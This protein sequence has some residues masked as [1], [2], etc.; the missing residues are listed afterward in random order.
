M[1]DGSSGA[2]LIAQRKWILFGLALLCHIYFLQVYPN[3]LP[4]NEL[5]RLLLVSAIVD[6]H[7]FQI[8]QA[9]RRYS[10]SEDKARFEG[11]F[12]SDK[13]IGVSLVALPAFILM[14]LIEFATGTH[15]PTGFAICFL[16]VFTITV[17]ALLFL[18]LIARFWQ[19]LR[20][21]AEL[22]PEFLF[23]L[24]FG[25]IAF[26]YSMQLISHYLLG[27]LLF[28]SLCSLWS[29][30]QEGG[31]G[32][33]LFWAGTAAGLALTME[34]PAV[35]PV[36]LV[37]IYALYAIRK[38]KG[39]VIF[40]L[41]VLAFLL[42][43]LA[44]NNSIFGSPFDVTYR[45]MTDRHTAQHVQGV[46]GVALPSGEALYGLLLS[47]HHGL[48]FTSPFLLFAV[49][50]LVCLIR[51]KKWRIEGWIF[52]GIISC[53]VFVYSGFSYWIGG[54]AFGPRYFGPTI[55]FLTTAAYFFFTEKRARENRLLSVVGIASGAISIVLITAGSIT[56]PYPPDP[57][58]D[59]SFFVSFPL[60]V[61]G[62]YGWN[63]GSWIGLSNLG[64]ALLFYTLLFVTY[65]VAIVRSGTQEI[66]GHSS[67]KR[68][69]ICAT[70]VIVLLIAGFW[71]S[72][73]GD[74]REYYA[75]GLIYTFLAKYEPAAIDMREALQKKSDPQMRGRIERAL[76]QLENVLNNHVPREPQP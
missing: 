74:A 20:P 45:H 23:L 53:F 65:L 5:S 27:I 12:Y 24:T 3:F 19:K 46:V 4:P 25:T 58:R 63:V 72:P 14:R 11:H 1:I 26:T 17:P 66:P 8:D 70:I 32:K 33:R 55:P 52:S 56:F 40:A 54:W 38:I 69:L 59:P 30:K 49:P 21:E 44:Y 67:V 48:F 68:W 42:L 43:M 6:D 61:H 22:I 76:V 47:R 34:Y 29:Y 16:R 62:G 39:V 13:A 36:A 18:P 15:F 31:S 64:P 50:G 9:M 2:P 35:F 41:P 28:C 51:N 7:T 73:A 75:R 71:T 37:C 10:D 60:L 57:L